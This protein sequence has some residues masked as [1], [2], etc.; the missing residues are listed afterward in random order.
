MPEQTTIQKAIFLYQKQLSA[1]EFLVTFLTQSGQITL[2]ALGLNKLLSKNASNLIQGALCEIEYFQA[3]YANKIGRMKKVSLIGSYQFSNE[4]TFL[5]LK[6]IS[7]W[8]QEVYLQNEFI[9]YYQIV[10]QHQQETHFFKILNIFLLALIK[11]HA[12]KLT[13]NQCAMCSNEHIVDFE[14]A[15]GG[16]LCATHS[17]KQ[18]SAQLLEQIYY[19]FNHVTIYISAPEN[20]QDKIIYYL[21]TQFCFENKILNL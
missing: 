4:K 8:A 6:R 2:F 11:Y 21:M 16:F 10:N 14:L 19:L 13:L 18:Y 9:D 1:N 12:I 7:T 3:R 20:D 17:S 15:Q 5:L